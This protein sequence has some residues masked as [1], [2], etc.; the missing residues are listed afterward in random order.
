MDKAKRLLKSRA[1]TTAIEYALIGS[2]LSIAILGGAA[3]V[4]TDVSAL[5]GDVQTQVSAAVGQTED[6]VP[7]AEEN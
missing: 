4:G 5:Y 2:L 7:A 3:A 1:G 6:P